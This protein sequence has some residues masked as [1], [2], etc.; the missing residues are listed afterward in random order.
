MAERV[1]IDADELKAAAGTI[2]GFVAE[3]EAVGHDGD[4]PDLV[5]RPYSIKG[6]RSSLDDFV[7]FWAGTRLD[8]IKQCTD[9]ADHFDDI[10]D[11]F[12]EFDVMLSERQEGD[13]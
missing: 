12:T 13:N 8:L 2:K 11:S 9:V 6:L 1:L 4:L 7:D 5:E 3:F 10:A